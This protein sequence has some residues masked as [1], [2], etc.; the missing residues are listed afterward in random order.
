MDSS[1]I[2]GWKFMDGSR[3]SEY[4]RVE[5]QLRHNSFLCDMTFSELRLSGCIPL[6]ETGKKSSAWDDLL[7][8]N[9][10]C[11]GFMANASSICFVYHG[12]P[13]NSSSREEGEI[14]EIIEIIEIC[15]LSA[16][17]RSPRGTG[18]DLPGVIW[19]R[20]IRRSE[21]DCTRQ[22]D[23]HQYQN[24]I[25][26]E[27]D[28]ERW[29]WLAVFSQ[30]IF[31]STGAI[32]WWAGRRAVAWNF[33]LKHRQIH[34]ESTRWWIYQTSFPDNPTVSTSAQQMG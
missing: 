31:P 30:C 9:F 17:Q 33:I 21:C 26:F 32:S 29:P 12:N 13:P 8:A 14:I 34:M 19:P 16:S 24:A 6:L 22:W 25:V 23:R 5:Q 3:S 20:A 4:T 7:L 15:H 18:A 27:T 10:E 28:T 1:R 11:F 2:D